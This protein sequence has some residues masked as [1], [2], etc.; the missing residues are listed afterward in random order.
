[1]HLYSTL[2]QIRIIT[3]RMQRLL[4]KLIEDII[5]NISVYFGGFMG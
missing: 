5:Q 2:C 3:A 1:M 4:H